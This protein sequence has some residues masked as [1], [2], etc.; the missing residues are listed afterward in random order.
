[1]SDNLDILTTDMVEDDAVI[2]FT[3][4]TT[5]N[6]TA[7]LPSPPPS[8]A[9]TS[10]DQEAKPPVPRGPPKKISD[11]P[12]D[13]LR[14]TLAYVLIPPEREEHTVRPFYKKGMLGGYIRTG[15]NIETNVGD[16]I[17]EENIEIAQTMLVCKKF[18]EIGQEVF[19]GSA[20]FQFNSPDAFKWWLKQIGPKNLTKVRKL[21]ITIHPGFTTPHNIRSVFDLTAEEKYLQ[22]FQQLRARHGLEYLEILVSSRDYWGKSLHIEY[23]DH[24]EVGKYRQ[25]LLDEL[26]RYRNLKCAEIRDNTYFWGDRTQCEQYSWVLRRKADIQKTM[27]K[28]PTKRMSLGELIEEI[29]INRELEEMTRRAQELEQMLAA[30]RS[31]QYDNAH[32]ISSGMGWRGVN[33]RPYQMQ[34]QS[35]NS[36]DTFFYRNQT[37]KRTNTYSKKNQGLASQR[38]FR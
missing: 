16:E 15:N 22:V 28:P 3:S 20:W 18:A 9:R 14:K 13:V 35:T 30:K 10:P 6:P 17:T 12:D 4:P 8:E 23:A 19:Y 27:V 36:T 29:R 34:S 7:T 31:R 5:V 21:A 11:L 33:T 25:L 37:S 24:D 2:I 26:L 38:V 1:M 32:P